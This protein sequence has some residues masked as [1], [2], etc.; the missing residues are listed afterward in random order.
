MFFNYAGCSGECCVCAI[1]DGCLASSGDDFYRPATKEEIIRRLDEDEY[2][3]YR[4]QMIETL[5]QS[6]GYS[7]RGKTDR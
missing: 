6:Y 1:G 7:Y 4:K 3:C 5:K 2:P